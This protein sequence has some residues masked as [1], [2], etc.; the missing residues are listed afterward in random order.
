MACLKVSN[1]SR[2]TRAASK[3]S[4]CNTVEALE[5]GTTISPA[6]EL[7]AAVDIQEHHRNIAVA[8]GFGHTAAL[9][10]DQL[11]QTTDDEEA[12]LQASGQLK[13]Q[14]QNQS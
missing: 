5:S 12:D 14:D 7:R 2:R 8:Q 13:R 3:Y 1:S 6:A 10:R 4:P 9:I 11:C